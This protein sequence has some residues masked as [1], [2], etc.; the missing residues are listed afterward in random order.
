LGALGHTLGNHAPYLGQ[1]NQL[2]LDV[3]ES[4]W[5]GLQRGGSLWGFGGR[6]DGGFDIGAQN[7]VPGFL[8]GKLTKVDAGL[9]CKAFGYR[10]CFD[11]WRGGLSLGCGCGLNMRQK[12]RPAFGSFNGAPIYA[13]LLGPAAGRRTGQL[14]FT[15]NE[16]L[17]GG[18]G[19]GNWLGF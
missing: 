17:S 9:R 13:Q 18:S 1:R 6:G 10:G 8:L 3:W 11:P 5:D 19:C 4:R 2:S 16:F 14:A 7:L 12:N 15:G